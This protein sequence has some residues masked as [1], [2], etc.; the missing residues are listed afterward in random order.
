MSVSVGISAGAGGKDSGSMG[1]G[2][3]ISGGLGVSGGAGIGSGVSTGGVGLSG[4]IG[5]SGGASTNVGVPSNIGMSGGIGVSGSGSIGPTGNAGVKTNAIVSLDVESGVTLEEPNST[6]ELSESLR[7]H[8]VCAVCK[9]CRQPS[10]TL[11]VP[12]YNILSCLFA[13]F[14]TPFW[15][16][17]MCYK[18]KDWNCW[19][20][21]HNCG[22]CGKY[23]D[24]YSSC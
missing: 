2:I 15:G 22:S 24:T 16:C 5:V 10:H 3:G 12:Q 4:G 1:G 17:Y 8:S 23:I 18:R 13:Y 6:P 20:C 11:T 19:N 7:S 9:L 14:C 21:R